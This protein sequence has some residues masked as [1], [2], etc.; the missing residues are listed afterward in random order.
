MSLAPPAV[1]QL[2]LLLLLLLLLML[3]Q[4]RL[5]LAGGKVVGRGVEV[6]GAGGVVRVVVVLS[7][8]V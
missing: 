4:V 8:V 2:M 1:R 3:G 7:V 6:V 5:P